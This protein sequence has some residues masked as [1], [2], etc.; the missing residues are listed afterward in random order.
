MINRTCVIVA[1]YN[2]QQYINEQLRSIESC[3]TKDD[4][5]LIVDDGSV[6][7]TLDICRDVSCEF[8]NIIIKENVYNQGVAKNF[9][10]ALRSDLA[11]TSAY[12]AFADQDDCWLPDKITRAKTII[13]S[14]QNSHY[15]PML[16]YSN[17]DNY[18]AN[19]KNVLYRSCDENLARYIRSDWFTGYFYSRALGCTFLMNSSLVELLNSHTPEIYPRLHDG[20]VHSVAMLFGRVLFDSDYAGINRRISGSNLTRPKNGFAGK[21]AEWHRSATAPFASEAHEIMHCY[22]DLLTDTQRN[23]ISNLDYST[24]RISAR[25]YISKYCCPDLDTSRKARFRMKILSG[26]L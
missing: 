9:M 21:V 4:V 11:S 10:A 7:G 5:I 3:L 24:K 17:V 12:V 14:E 1:T 6:D 23:F 19:L 22:G 16:Y 25:Y 15:T 13:E 2:G 18:D 26:R 20:W 8:N